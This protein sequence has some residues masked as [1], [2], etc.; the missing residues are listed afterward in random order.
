MK[1]ITFQL[2]RMTEE[3]IASVKI[4]TDRR[5]DIRSI[6][7]A[8]TIHHLSASD[9][10]IEWAWERLSKDREG[11]DWLPVDEYCGDTNSGQMQAVG[12][13]VKLITNY[14]TTLPPSP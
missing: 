10:D 9:E 1:P 11:V 8:L 7:F 3:E 2:R 6:S 14:L 12:A 13:I 4:K 5:K